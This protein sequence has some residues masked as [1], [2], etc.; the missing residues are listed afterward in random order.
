M[1]EQEV[2]YRSWT[3]GARIDQR[4]LLEERLSEVNPRIRVYRRWAME[5][6]G[7]S[8]HEIAEL[9]LQAALNRRQSLTRRLDRLNAAIADAGDEIDG[10]AETVELQVVR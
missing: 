5:R 6:G 1:R 3:P 7:G 10:D 2:D 9:H 4:K 8:L